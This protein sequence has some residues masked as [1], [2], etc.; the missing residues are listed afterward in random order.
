MGDVS[1]TQK[2]EM[3]AWQQTVADHGSWLRGLIAARLDPGE[4]VEDILQETL[5]S[6]LEGGRPQEALR[7]VKGWLAGIAR[8]KVRQHIDR[9]CRERRLQ[10]KAEDFGEGSPQPPLPLPDQFLL[11]RERLALVARALASL[12][13][14]T[15]SLLR[16]KYLR[17]W[18]YRRIGD[19]LGLNE[20]GVT[21]RLRRARHLLRTRIQ[22][23]YDNP[24]N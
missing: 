1:R 7:D 11:D 24:E 20:A 21:N 14:E 13:T 5:Q 15:A 9:N 10:A 19:E 23:L 22:D 17:G 8:N 18:S 6:A 16:C 3:M 4:P 12:D 2:A